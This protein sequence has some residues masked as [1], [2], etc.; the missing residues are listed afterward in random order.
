MAGGDATVPPD[1]ADRWMEMEFRRLNSGVVTR[2]RSLEALLA[3]KEP[4]LT[5]RDGEAFV[6]D[7]AGLDRLAAA[8]TP[9]ERRA[10]ML[11]IT[12]HFTADAANEAYVSDATAAA[13]LRKAEGWTESYAFRDGRMW[14]PL[15][16]GMELIRKYGG[17]VQALYL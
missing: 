15:S 1:P 8:A 17:A 5:T 12:L 14:L 11:P 6:L 13:V 7:R 3:E 4:S 9:G 10:L 16:L 2:R